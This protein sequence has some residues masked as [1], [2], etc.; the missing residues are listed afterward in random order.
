MDHE[1]EQPRTARDRKQEDKSTQDHGALEC[2]L[3]FNPVRG[4]EITSHV[5]QMDLSK[6]M[7]SELGADSVRRDVAP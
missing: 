2:A 4:R 6:L 3:P 7:N 1:R 5:V